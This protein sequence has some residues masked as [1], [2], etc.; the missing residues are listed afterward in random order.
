LGALKTVPGLSVP[1]RL[2]EQVH[3]QLRVRVVLELEMLAERLAAM[4]TR[5]KTRIQTEEGGRV[6]LRTLKSG[7][8][9][10]LGHLDRGMDGVAALLDVRGLH[11]DEPA[12]SDPALSPIPHISTPVYRLSD[13]FPTDQHVE[14][15]RKL[16]KILE[17]EQ[18]EIRRLQEHS[19]VLGLSSD[20]PIAADLIPPRENLALASEGVPRPHSPGM[21]RGTSG[22]LA[23]SSW[24][25][26]GDETRAGAG[27]LGV[28]LAIALWRL[29]SWN[30]EGW[31]EFEADK[32]GRRV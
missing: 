22:I 17:I 30:G 1:P 8:G 7:E 5:Y 3:T 2:A 10:H 4:T 28:D 27:E 13:L 26:D 31:E 21:S 14:T 18:T 29:K 6:V 19:Q 24:P 15:A 32:Y 20:D 11:D 12:Y 23:L 16:G 9:K 25:S